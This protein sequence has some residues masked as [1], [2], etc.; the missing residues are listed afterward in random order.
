MKLNPDCVRDI[1]IT[2]EEYPE[3]MELYINEFAKKLPQYSLMEVYYCCSRLY[4]G[5]YINFE[6]L[7]NG[8]YHNTIVGDLTFFGHEFLQKIKNDNTWS[9]TKSIATKIGSFS[10]DVISQIAVNVITQLIS[11]QLPRI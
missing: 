1:L 4:E 9:K 5:G 11:Q 7:T 8:G 3:P 2:I 6:D 10:I